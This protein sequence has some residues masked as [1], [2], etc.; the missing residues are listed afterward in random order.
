MIEVLMYTYPEI[1]G[2]VSLFCIVEVP[3]VRFLVSQNIESCCKAK[4]TQIKKRTHQTLYYEASPQIKGAF[5][6]P[7]RNRVLLFWGLSKFYFVK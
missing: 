3:C 6:C 4:A 2:C 1:T 7:W 5:G